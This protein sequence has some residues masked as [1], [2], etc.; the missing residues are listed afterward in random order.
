MEITFKLLKEE[1]QRRELNQFGNN[2][3]IEII[4][5]TVR[6]KRYI[7][8]LKESERINSRKRKTGKSK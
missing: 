4:K 8:F 5:D 2:S 6:I 3:R 1:I 7:I